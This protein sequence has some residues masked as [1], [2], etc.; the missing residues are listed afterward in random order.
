[1]GNSPQRG[2]N[3]IPRI[4]EYFARH[5]NQVVTVK[6]LGTSLRVSEI[7]IRTSL[8]S[9]RHYHRADPDHVSKQIQTVI[10]GHSWCYVVPG[11]P[12][13]DV[14][15]EPASPVMLNGPA[16]VDSSHSDQGTASSVE[17]SGDSF[18]S[19]PVP[20]A[21]ATSARS[22]TRRVFEEVS[23]VTDGF[24]IRDEDDVLYRATRL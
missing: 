7:S 14:A 3:V 11:L 21:V 2:K 15:S 13:P 9:Y 23:P 18:V 12:V 1:M 20:I 10:R 6:M 8:N 19:K 16:P 4:I 22:S 24:V 17:V 5:P